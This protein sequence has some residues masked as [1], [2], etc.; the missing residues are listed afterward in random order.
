MYASHIPADILQLV[1]DTYGRKLRTHTT[2]CRYS[3]RLSHPHRRMLHLLSRCP[4]ASRLHALH[5]PE[6]PVEQRVTLEGTYTASIRVEKFIS[7][8]Q[9]SDGT[10]VVARIEVLFYR[11]GTWRNSF[12]KLNSEIE[13]F[14]RTVID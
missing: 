2:G 12:H 14:F 13:A 1:V 5:S 8:R 11:F 10:W 9:A 3:N 6:L 4:A 7:R